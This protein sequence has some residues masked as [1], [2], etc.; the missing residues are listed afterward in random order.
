[1]CFINLYPPYPIKPT[2]PAAITAAAV[3]T[4]FN[5]SVVDLALNS[6]TL[7]LISF[8]ALVPASL[9]EAITTLPV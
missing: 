9:T 8:A 2:G 4:V 1:M 7:F 3:P 5:L 6:F